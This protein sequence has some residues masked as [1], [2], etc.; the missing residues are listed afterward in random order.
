MLTFNQM[1]L[2]N[3]VIHRVGNRL[4]EEGISFSKHPFDFDSELTLQLMLK[5]FLQPFKT[6]V[7]YQFIHDEYLNK[8]EVYELAG[9]IFSEP[10]NLFDASIAI[11]KDLY[12]KSNHPKIKAGELYIVYMED[13]LLEDEVLSGVGIFKTENKETFLTV[14]RKEDE[15]EIYSIDG[16]N[17]A[18]L[19]K[20]CIILNT[21]K[22]TGYIVALPSNYE[23][24][25]AAYWKDTFLSLMPRNDDYHKTKAAIEMCKEFVE[26]FAKENELNTLDTADLKNKTLKYFSEND[27]FNLD[28]FTCE[29]L[30]VANDSF[31]EFK[32]TYENKN[33]V[34]IE[35]DFEIAEKAVKTSQKF[36]KAVLKLDKNFHV[37]IHG[38]RNCIEKGFDEESG[39]HWYKL[40]YDR[41][42]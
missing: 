38:D 20:G 21:E 41:E 40:Y 28:N 11:A 31:H 34:N 30:G 36:F 29:T 7:Y 13:I 3:V 16:I 19:D 12:E 17:I 33:N 39:K 1:S 35:D 32:K 37:Y 9:E 26:I 22:E 27:S 5:Y 4:K 2:E 23:K 14:N 6:P 18:K 42:E 25:E 8:N 10:Q 15:F 24:N